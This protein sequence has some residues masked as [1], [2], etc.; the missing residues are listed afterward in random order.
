MLPLSLSVMATVPVRAQGRAAL[1]Q[2]LAH[3]SEAEVEQMRQDAHYRF[4]G[5]LLF[6]SAS[7]LVD[8]NGEERAA[9]QEE[10][11]DIDLHAY[12]GIRMQDQRTGV[13][14]PLIDKHIVL[15]GRGE[16]EHLVLDRLEPADRE[17]YVAYK[18]GAVVQPISKTR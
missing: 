9:T 7:F 8:E 4:E 14:D 13:H 3:H 16:F 18:N 17:A 10:I 11:A 2:L 5:E 6:Y 15:L 1:D 12:D